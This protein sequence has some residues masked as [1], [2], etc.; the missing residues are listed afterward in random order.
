MTWALRVAES[1][2]PCSWYPHTPF[3]V[4]ASVASYPKSTTRMH[5]RSTSH[6]SDPHTV[7]H[8]TI[9]PRSTA[10]S[11]QDKLTGCNG[12]R[13]LLPF[14]LLLSC[15]SSCSSVLL[16]LLV[17]ARQVCCS[18]EDL[19]HC[20]LP[21]LSTAKRKRKTHTPSPL[22]VPQ[23]A[24]S[25]YRCTAKNVH[26]IP[27]FSTAA[28]TQLHYLNTAHGPADGSTR[29]SCL[30]TAECTRLR[31]LSTVRKA[32]HTCVRARSIHYH[33]AHRTR[34][35]Y[36]ASWRGQIKRIPGTNCTKT[37]ASGL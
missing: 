7:H 13:I 2:Q 25:Q 11:D 27:P 15:S 33:L 21:A 29:L 16:L 35:Q 37:A 14:L 8:S 24:H 36:R 1:R 34:G 31:D 22:S 9:L 12:Q 18:H 6:S 10:H 26:H 4:L 3:S 23:N 20:T 17:R 19:V 28:R 5:H 30:S 32:A